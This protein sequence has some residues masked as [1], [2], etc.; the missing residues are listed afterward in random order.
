MFQIQT[1]CTILMDLRNS[2]FPETLQ[3]KC[4]KLQSRTRTDSYEEI[5][6]KIIKSK[7]NPN[8]VKQNL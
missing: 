3:N 4:S 8:P 2:T 7:S 1:R 5:R 6:N